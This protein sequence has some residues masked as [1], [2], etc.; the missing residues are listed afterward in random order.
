MLFSLD[1]DEGGELQRP[2]ETLNFALVEFH[3]T[4]DGSIQSVVGADANTGAVA[5]ARTTLADNNLASVYW[6]TAV[7][8][9]AES[10]GM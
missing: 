5:V 1:A 4:G 9:D 10:F 2:G 3:H 7:N 6:F 8:F